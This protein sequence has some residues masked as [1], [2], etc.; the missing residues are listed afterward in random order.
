MRNKRNGRDESDKNILHT[1]EIITSLDGCG[2]NGKE[3]E[4]RS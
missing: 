1:L 3:E 2:S 4:D